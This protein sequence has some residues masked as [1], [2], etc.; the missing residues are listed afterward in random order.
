MGFECAI[1][2]EPL[3]RGLRVCVV[4]VFVLWKLHARN[5]SDSKRDMVEL[6]LENVL[7]PFWFFGWRGKWVDV[8]LVWCKTYLTCR[9]TSS[10]LRHRD[11]WGWVPFCGTQTTAG[12]SIASILLCSS[13][14]CFKPHSLQLKL[15]FP[16]LFLS[17][18]RLLLLLVS[19]IHLSTFL[20]K[21][22]R[23]P[24]IYF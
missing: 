23:P 12:E 4:C 14:D 17:F 7:W 18:F 1:T 9:W 2:N 21:K 20:T 6:W 3:R 19:P 5:K 16:P 8:S 24:L 15:F 13:L 11:R 22:E 10:F